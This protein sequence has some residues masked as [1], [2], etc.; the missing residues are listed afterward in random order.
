MVLAHVVHVVVESNLLEFANG[1]DIRM[2]LVLELAVSPS[3]PASPA[4]LTPQY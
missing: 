3:L 2:V 1:G 4:I